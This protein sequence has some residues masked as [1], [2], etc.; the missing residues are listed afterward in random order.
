[1][2]LLLA[3]LL[4]YPQSCISSVPVKLTCQQNIKH[5]SSQILVVQAVFSATGEKWDRRSVQGP[6]RQ[7]S[8]T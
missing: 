1:M 7:L 6:C 8:V 3:L 4:I 5:S 2:L